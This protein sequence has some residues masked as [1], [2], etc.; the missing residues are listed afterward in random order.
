M[1]SQFSALGL[2][3]VAELARLQKVIGPKVGIG[4]V[5][6][7]NGSTCHGF[8][9]PEDLGEV[10]KRSSRGIQVDV[11]KPVRVLHA[12]DNVLA[13]PTALVGTAKHHVRRDDPQAE[14]HISPAPKLARRK[15]TRSSNAIDNLFSSLNS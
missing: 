13:G 12:Q 14:Q 5:D 15:K 3:L 1:D 6:M 9:P 8:A 4:E 10:V 11:V 7:A 2:V